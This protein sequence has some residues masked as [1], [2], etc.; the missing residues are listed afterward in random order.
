MKLKYCAHSFA[1]WPNVGCAYKYWTLSQHKVNTEIH[2]HEHE[3]EHVYVCVQWIWLC[4]RDLC[5]IIELNC[6]VSV[7]IWSLFWM[8]QTSF[9]P[10]RLARVFTTKC[11]NSLSLSLSPF[12]S[13]CLISYYAIC[14]CLAILRTYSCILK[15]CASKYDKMGLPAS[16]TKSEY[17]SEKCVSKV[18][19]I[20]EH[21]FEYA[22]PVYIIKCVYCVWN[23]EYYNMRFHIQN[24]IQLN[25]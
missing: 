10:M 19:S 22:M 3:H 15:I 7:C 18:F 13:L 24:W 16:T 4:F 2:G 9:H 8:A 23:R 14:I 12:I 20:S 11:E 17:S 21:E 5:A 25:L 1:F 6:F